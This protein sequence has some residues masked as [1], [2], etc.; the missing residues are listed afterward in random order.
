VV[1][2]L[3][4]GKEIHMRG[5]VTR[6]TDLDAEP[7]GLRFLLGCDQ[8]VAKRRY[9]LDFFEWRGTRRGFGSLRRRDQ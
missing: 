4:K 5:G 2:L 9:R 3:R 8:D 7:S 6:G 1:G